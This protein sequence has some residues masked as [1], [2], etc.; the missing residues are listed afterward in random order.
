MK[1]HTLLL[2]TFLTAALAMPTTIERG[3]LSPLLRLWGQGWFQPGDPC[4]YY[5]SCIKSSAHC[6]VYRDCRCK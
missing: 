3:I 4:K 1:M 5:C 2:L 6:G